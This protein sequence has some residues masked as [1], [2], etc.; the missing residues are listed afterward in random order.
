MIALLYVVVMIATIV[1]VDALIF[2][3]HL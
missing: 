1:T 3:N 2:S